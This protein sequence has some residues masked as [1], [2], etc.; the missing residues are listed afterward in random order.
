MMTKLLMLTDYKL[1][2]TTL[3]K[4][5]VVTVDF[6]LGLDLQS[7][8]AAI[9]AEITTDVEEA[10]EFLAIQDELGAYPEQESEETS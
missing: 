5:S 9:D 10:I 1:A 7:E 6:W 8:R 3:R 2:H 4:G